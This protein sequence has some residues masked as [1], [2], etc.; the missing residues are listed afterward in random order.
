MAKERISDY[1]GEELTVTY[2]RKL[3]IHAAECGRAKSELFNTKND[4][5][6]SPDAEPLG[7][8]VDIL[9]RCPTG[10]LTYARKDGV[11]EAAPDEATLN[12]S[13]HGPVFLRGDIHIKTPDGDRQM[14][15]LALCRC[16]A[17]KNKPFCDNSHYAVKFNDM[18]AVSGDSVDLAS[19]PGPLS[20]TP[21]PNGPV[22][23]TGDFTIYTGSGRAA[24]TQKEVYLCRCGKSANKP[25]CD[26]THNS[27][28]FEAD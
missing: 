5:W 10:A 11:A 3:C 20:V 6:C 7:K 22:K 14:T 21:F 18:G 26:G 8:S 13:P 27:I 16:G 12:V 17:S 23:V 28:G 4:P 1:E 19:E 15:R 25:F 24:M 9:E 2:D